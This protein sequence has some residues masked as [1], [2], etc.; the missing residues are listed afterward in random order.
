MAD[1]KDQ[2]VGTELEVEP[3]PEADAKGS[4]S[5]EP[6][7]DETKQQDYEKHQQALDQERANAKKARQRA[8]EAE[9]RAEKV[10]GQLQAVQDEMDLL[11]KEL[12]GEL[13]KK[14]FADVLKLDPDTTDVPEM[15]AAFQR[16]GQ[17]VIDTKKK[18]TDYDDYIA[19]QQKQ[20]RTKAQTKQHET[21]V[22]QILS[23]CDEEYGAQ[24][25]NEAMAQADVL[26][27]DGDVTA[28]ADYDGGIRLMRKA[29]KA[30][31]KKHAAEK[32][33]AQEKKTVPTDTGLRNASP[34]E[35]IDS[36]EFKGGSIDEVRKDMSKKMK[37]GAWKGAF[38]SSPPS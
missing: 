5:E 18:L 23:F 6:S 14:E 19:T 2:S 1:A 22:E 4:K 7:E 24:Y 9:A 12:K 16:L 17:E 35:L 3:V 34:L 37:T 8:T 13:S 25:R 32:K 31:L 30:V 38:A 10:G 28:P 21:M 15:V 29:Y 36:E 11:K 33:P 20:S 26:V 27:A